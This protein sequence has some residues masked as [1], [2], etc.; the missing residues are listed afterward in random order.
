MEVTQTLALG[1]DMSVGNVKHLDS[2][3]KQMQEKWG[4]YFAFLCV[5]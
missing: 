2:P 5:S 1:C 4:V 3:Q